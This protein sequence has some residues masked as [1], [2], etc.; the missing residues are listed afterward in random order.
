MSNVLAKIMATKH[1][2]VAQGKQQHSVADLQ[3]LINQ[4][5]ACRGFFQTISRRVA[6]NQSAVIAEVKKASPSKG[7]IRADFDPVAIAESYVAG[8]ATCLSVLTDENYFKGSDHYLKQVKQAVDLPVLRKDFMVD[9]WQIYQSRALGADCVLLIVACLTDQQL[10]DYHQLASSLGMDVLMEV[11]DEQ[12][13]QRA[14]TTPAKLIGIN[15]RNLKT[16]ETSLETSQ[17]LCGMVDDGRLVVSESGIHVSAD[18][19]YLIGQ[20]IRTFLIGESF[21]RHD[22]P[23]LQLQQLMH[24]QV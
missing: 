15:N 14:L 2:E 23:G 7:I 21:M 10:Q 17:R 3:Q 8:G 11:H 1:D 5:P 18:I 20:N 6:A 13:M 4:Q 16:F 12:E 24:G 19:D 22:D 9:E